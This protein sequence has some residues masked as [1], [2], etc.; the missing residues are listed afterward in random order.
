MEKN[1]KE[2]IEKKTNEI[3]SIVTKASNIEE[4]AKKNG[5]HM[6][7][8]KVLTSYLTKS[9]ELEVKDTGIKLSIFL[10]KILKS[11]SDLNEEVIKLLELIKVEALE[12][13]KIKKVEVPVLKEKTEDFKNILDFDDEN[14]DFDD[15]NL[16][17][18][19]ENV[20]SALEVPIQVA[21]KS[22]NNGINL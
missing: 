15:E 20:I 4:F 17:L 14:L 12:T 1:G 13:E 8:P 6:K 18:E 3:I 22:N 9:L 19:L 11:K 10:E 5:K 21:N 16:D 2:L 7:K